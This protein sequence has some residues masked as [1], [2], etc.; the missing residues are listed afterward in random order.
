MTTTIIPTDAESKLFSA[1]L[2]VLDDEGQNELIRRTGEHA[3]RIMLERHVSPE[4]ASLEAIAQVASYVRQ[5][6][7]DFGTM[8]R[9]EPMEPVI[10]HFA[11]GCAE[12]SRSADTALPVGAEVECENDHG[13][14]TVERIAAM[15]E[16]ASDG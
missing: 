12:F 14:T 4:A 15:G 10:M 5:R 2:D 9:V 8:V 13:I 7:A 16:D 1:L 6:L 11:C 3:A